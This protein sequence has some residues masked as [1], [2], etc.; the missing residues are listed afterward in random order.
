MA[1]RGPAKPF[2]LEAQYDNEK[3]RALLWDKICA[4]VGGDFTIG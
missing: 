4:A 2:A 3:T 1:T